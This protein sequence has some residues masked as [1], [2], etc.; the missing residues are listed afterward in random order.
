MRRVSSLRLWAGVGWIHSFSG[1]SV[2]VR[3]TKEETIGGKAV[4]LSRLKLLCHNNNWEYEVRQCQLSTP[5][6]GSTL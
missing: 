1:A 2:Y 6:G 5:V 4:P 3:N